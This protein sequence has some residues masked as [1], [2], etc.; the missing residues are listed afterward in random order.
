VADEPAL[1]GLI[2]TSVVIDLERVVPDT[3][4]PELSIAAVTLAEL[5]AGP[6][7]TDDPT[8]RA[9]RQERLQRTEATFDAIPFDAAAARAYG[10]VYAEVAAAGRKARGK[11]ALDLLIAATALAA[12]LTLYTRNPSD[13]E[14]LRGLIDVASVQSATSAR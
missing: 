13:F 6:H 5:A 1:R 9:R 7:A 12:E 2:D 4:P 11:R 10:R 8:E 3:L 14:G